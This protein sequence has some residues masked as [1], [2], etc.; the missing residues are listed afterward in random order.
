MRC[1]LFV[2]FCLFVNR[3]WAGVLAF[4][5]LW[6]GMVWLAAVA[7]ETWAPGVPPAAGQVAPASGTRLSAIRQS[8]SSLLPPLSPAP[9]SPSP[10]S[11]G[12]SPVT[13][14]AFAADGQSLCCGSNEGLVVVSW[15]ERQEVRRLATELSRILDLRFSPRGDYLLVAGGIPGEAGQ[16]E[17]WSWPRGELVQRHQ[18]HDDVLQQAAWSPSGQRYAVA[19]FTGECSVHAFVVGRELDQERERELDRAVSRVEVMELQRFSGHAQGVLAIEFWDEQSCL[20]GGLDQTVRWWG[21][22]DAAVKRSL[23]NH[24][25]AVVGLLPERGQEPSRSRRLWSV[26]VDQTV[27]LWQPELGRLVRFARLSQPPTVACWDAASG[28]ILVGGR[29]GSVWRVSA[30]SLEVASLGRWGEQQWVTAL[31]VHP[32]GRSVVVAGGFGL[33]VVDSP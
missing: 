21:V 20:S 30:E 15:P 4:A 19:S 1:V 5:S 29:D 9:L 12:A 7:G 18:G 8:P 28:Q 24:V 6:L 11:L 26:G 22:A 3:G 31:A 16:V 25:G 33:Q 2:W 10:L 32:D 17:V 13:A 23:T 27:R 14:L